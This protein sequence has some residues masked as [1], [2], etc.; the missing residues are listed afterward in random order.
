MY[1]GLF[2]HSP[3]KGRLW[4]LPSFGSYEQSCNKHPWAGFCV[5]LSFQ[6]LWVNTKEHVCCKSMFSF[7][8]SC[9]TVFQSG[10]TILH[11]DQQ[12]MKVAIAPHPRQHLVLSVFQILALLIGVYWYLVVSC[13]YFLSAYLLGRGVC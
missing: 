12:L 11:S 2:I 7:V 5:D 6:V 4:L 8:R 1:H 9:Q 10:C 13:A 3:T